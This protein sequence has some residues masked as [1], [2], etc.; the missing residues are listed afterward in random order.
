[1]N[2]EAP[3]T[4]A[5]E[6][7][8]PAQAPAPTPEQAT[9]DPKPARKVSWLDKALGRGQP[10][11]PAS[12]PDANDAPAD[13]KPA[14]PE[15]DAAPKAAK[16]A[17]ELEREVERRA[18]LRAAD[19]DRQR[20]AAAEEAA[21][22][23]LRARDPIAYV[24][25]EEQRER[26]EAFAREIGQLVK[27]TATEHDRAVLDPIMAALPAKVVSDL[28]KDPPM[29]LDGRARLVK[30]AIAA[31]QDAAR[32][33]GAAEAE[34]KL[35]A[36]AAFRKEVLAELRAGRDDE[37]EP[38]ALTGAP[39]HRANADMNAWMRASLKKTTYIRSTK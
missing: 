1:M 37:A 39:L 17:A 18:A 10:K 36:S 21:R 26:D 14:A 34:K 3:A 7:A 22:K 16:P 11:P 23:E 25:Q 19:L 8:A 12:P 20:Q 33:E 32:A 38:D 15:P 4:D 27:R 24:E 2:D 6:Q 28:M 9:A 30:R 31:L 13:E 5:P 29:G 35:R